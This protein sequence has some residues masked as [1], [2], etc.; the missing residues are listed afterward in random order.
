[1][2]N[3]SPWS[4]SASWIF[5]V[6]G[7]ALGDG[8]V[9]IE[10]GRIIAVESTGG[11]KADLELGEAAILPGLVNAHT[12]LDLSGL[13]GLCPPSPDFTGW[14]RDVISH[15]RN[16]SAEQTRAAIRSGLDQSVRSGTTLLGDISAGGLAG[17]NL[18]R[19]RFGPSC[20]TN[21]WV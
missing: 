4:L 14:L 18:P 11:K 8:R 17:L 6:E 7:P 13:R 15:R 12:H 16:T 19:P 9:V 2:S 3:T 5:P 10:N 1:M 20:F 21:C